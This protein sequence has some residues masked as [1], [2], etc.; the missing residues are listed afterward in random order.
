LPSFADYVIVGSGISGVSIAN[1][2]L[3]KQPTAKIV[4]L[5]ARRACSGATGRNGGHTKAAS[6]RSFLDHERQYGT[7]E[8]VKIARLEYANVQ[9]THR[10]AREHNNDCTSTPCDSVDIIYSQSH[11]DQG[12]KA[13][14]RIIE[15][16]GAE[17]PAAE[18]H[19]WTADEARDKFLCP[20]AL[21]AFSYPAGSLSAYRF[22]TGILKLALNKGLNLQT[23][24]PV[25]SIHHYATDSGECKW[26]A[27]TSRGNITTPNLILATNGYT[28]H[29]LPEMQGLIVPLH[30][31]VVAQRPG[32][33]LP[34]N[35]LPNTYSFVLEHGYEY[36]I[37]R[38]PGS[39]NA[40]DIIIG[41]GI[42][43]LPNDGVSVF[44]NTDD[45]AVEPTITQ[46]LRNCTASYFGP[47]W[48]DD[49]VDGRVKQEWSGVMGASA[50]G[51]PYVGAV[52]DKPGL[53]ICASFNGHGMVWCL[54]SA[55]ALVEMMTGDEVAQR[56][57]EKW[58]PASARMSKGRM[59]KTFKGGDWQNT[60][61]TE[62]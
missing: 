6:Y 3:S 36:M 46:Y 2:I 59:S 35:G 32:N 16:L 15:T 14:D 60:T 54:K 55:E 31:Q 21:G 37:I 41:G 1:N 7:A 25:H 39:V 23:N 4:L 62:V 38:P 45:T 49:H 12:K 17:D 33:N 58:F 56:E 43:Q 52:P 10:L 53:W 8:A 48:G 11:L 24:T 29:L 13:I 28:A 50:D 30:G 61:E 51:L 20:G 9:Q 19:I 18:Y 44:G 22:A 27:T 47:N 34:Q 26:S 40:G 57:V 42:H 5:E